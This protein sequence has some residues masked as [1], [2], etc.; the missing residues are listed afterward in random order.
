LKTIALLVTLFCLGL[1]LAGAYWLGGLERHL[2]E[3][4]LGQIG[5]WAP[6][7]Y[8]LLY[9]IATFL[10][11]PSTPLNLSGGAVFGI[12]WGTAWTTLGAVV[13][14]VICFWFSRTIQQSRH[15][16]N[17]RELIQSRFAGRW[18]EFDRELAAG[19]V[20]YM[21][22]IRL[23]PLLPYGLVN[24]GAGLTRVKF[25]D[26]LWGTLLGTT[27]GLLP[28]VMMGAGLTELR[29]GTLWPFLLS[30]TLASLLIAGATWYRRH[31]K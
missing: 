17:G 24:F 20:F 25:R 29:R 3:A 13:A 12:W 23:L 14:A 21:V 10:L 11:F 9:G 8:V 6:L 30:S 15:F 16:M 22:A 18:Q 7:L 5:F 26:Y 28:F 19:G 1:T 31:R 2:V 4:W 27:P